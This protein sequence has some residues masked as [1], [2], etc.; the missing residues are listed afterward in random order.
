MRSHEHRSAVKIGRTYPISEPSGTEWT[1][2]GLRAVS[3]SLIDAHED[4]IHHRHGVTIAR[5][6][7]VGFAEEGLGD[8]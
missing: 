3:T 1:N 5:E 7:L 8:I 4:N 2:V 6:T